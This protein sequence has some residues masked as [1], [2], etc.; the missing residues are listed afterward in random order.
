MDKVLELA[1]VLS[2]VAIAAY[3]MKLSHDSIQAMQEM[4]KQIQM[5]FVKS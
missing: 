5:M 1:L 3:S 2:I 4:N